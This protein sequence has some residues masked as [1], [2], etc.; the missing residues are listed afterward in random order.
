MTSK[1]S[2]ARLSFDAGRAILNVAG[3]AGIG[4]LDSV[5]DAAG[6]FGSHPARHITVI[7]TKAGLFAFIRV[8]FASE[9]LP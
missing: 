5:S 6:G 3:L 4:L 2:K 9:R 7:K 8:I 1:T